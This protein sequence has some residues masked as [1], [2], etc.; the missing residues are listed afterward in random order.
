MKVDVI[1]GG[2]AGLYFAILAKKAWPQLRLTVYERNRPGDTFGFGVV[3]SDETLETFEKYDRES[4]RAIT[5]NFAYWDDIEIHF[6][7]TVHRVGGN[8][9]CGCA[10]VTL[11]RLLH[12][13]ARAGQ[14]G[15]NGAADAAPAAGHESVS[16]VENCHAAASGIAR[17]SGLQITLSFKFLAFKQLQ[18]LAGKLFEA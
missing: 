9:F 4:Y 16:P 10:R 6:K 17:F 8:G 15:R 18:R 11:L 3:F 2:P 5:D 1:G 7:D 12:E 13:R 14:R